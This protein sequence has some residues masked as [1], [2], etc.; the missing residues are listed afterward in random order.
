MNQTPPVQTPDEVLKTQILEQL[1]GV[2]APQ[3]V[4][5]PVLAEV[6]AIVEEQLVVAAEP[7]TT[8][9]PVIV[10][11]PVMGNPFDSFDLESLDRVVIKD[12]NFLSKT[13][14]IRQLVTSVD[15]ATFQVVCLQSGYSAS[16]SALK[17]KDQGIVA[18]TIG[19]EYERTNRLYNMIYGKIADTS[20]GKISY[21]EFLDITSLADL[22]TVLYGVYASTFPEPE[23]YTLQCP[24]CQSKFEVKVPANQL[25]QVKDPEAYTRLQEIHM[26]LGNSPKTILEKSLLAETH[27]IRLKHS[28]VICDV[29]LPS[30]AR[31]LNMMKLASGNS[32]LKESM[33]TFS[34]LAFV[35]SLFV[36][37][38]ETFNRTSEVAYL[39]IEDFHD[40]FNIIS[41][42]HID[43]IKMLEKD[44][45]K[46]YS[47]YDLKFAIPKTKCAYC[48]AE[49]DNIPVNV[50]ETLFHN[51]LS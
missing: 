32:K 12:A 1:E 2:Q 14:A 16:M 25:T 6:P 36:P 29:K 13:N 47:K 27:R 46:A 49:Q 33:N 4:A 37:D 45:D 51:L 41:G 38:M 24:S 35:K 8:I 5:E 15:A 18:N 11:T 22:E 10:E 39:Q 7:I 30:L 40:M 31:Q 43:D 3:A 9:E 42:L 17:T 28:N 23:S 21:E 20:L 48:S 34:I 44:L 50:E 19:T 26:E